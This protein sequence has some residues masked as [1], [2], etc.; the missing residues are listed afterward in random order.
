MEK[1]NRVSKSLLSVTAIVN[2]TLRY[3]QNTHD[4]S[5]TYLPMQTLELFYNGFALTMVAA[6]PVLKLLCVVTFLATSG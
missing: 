6:V 1:P 5:L 2:L 3:Y 4:V